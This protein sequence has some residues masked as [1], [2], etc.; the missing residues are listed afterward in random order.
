MGEEA[1][2]PA[3]DG[4]L[5]RSAGR[6]GQAR[7][8][9]QE[10]RLP[11]PV[12]PGDDEKPLPREIDVDPTEDAALAEALLES[13]GADHPTRTS[14]ETKARNTTLITPFTVKNAASR[15]R[16]SPGLT[17]ACS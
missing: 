16:R 9:A 11:G 2:A 4:H 6:S 8:E 10:R 12:R 5:E 17:I 7:E 3:I 14:S 15:R 13:A 1:D